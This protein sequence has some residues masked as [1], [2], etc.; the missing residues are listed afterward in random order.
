MGVHG[1]RMTAFE[2]RSVNSTPQVCMDTVKGLSHRFVV[3]KQLGPQPNF[4]FRHPLVRGAFVATDVV[5][6]K[7]VWSQ[8]LVF[9]VV[10]DLV[11]LLR[12]VPT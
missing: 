5:R 11:R 4:V 3:F 8:S 6:D 9:D 1:E 7:E 12:H 2:K 10:D